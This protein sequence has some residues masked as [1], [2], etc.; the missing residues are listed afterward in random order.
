MKYKTNMQATTTFASGHG[1]NFTLP[2]EA[3]E[4]AV[5]SAHKAI[6]QISGFEVDIFSMLGMRNL[7]AFIGE[8]YAASLISVTGAQFK[9]NPHQ[10][11]YPDLLLMDSYGKNLYEQLEA[12]GKVREKGPFSPFANGGIEVKATCGSVPTPDDCLKHLVYVTRLNVLG[13]ELSE[14]GLNIIVDT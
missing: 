1:A 6:D 9:K 3:F 2:P 5:V 4:D 10:D 11:G 14:V 12:T 7:S 8:L 13:S